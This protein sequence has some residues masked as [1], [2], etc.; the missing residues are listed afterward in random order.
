[1]VILLRYF[2]HIFKV[3]KYIYHC[4]TFRVEKLKET[5]ITS[6]SCQIQTEVHCGDCGEVAITLSNNLRS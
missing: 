1:M 5:E 6:D 4:Q 2:F 3:I